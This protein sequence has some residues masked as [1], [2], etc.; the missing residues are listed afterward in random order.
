MSAA[1][2]ASELFYARIGDSDV[3]TTLFDPA[4]SNAADSIT[5]NRNWMPVTMPYLGV[6]FIGV[7]RNLDY[8]KAGLTMSACQCRS[9]FVHALPIGNKLYDCIFF[10]QKSNREG[11]GTQ[12]SLVL[13]SLHR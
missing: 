2:N 9:A 12:D 13:L 8:Y 5:I 3:F 4:H 6:S 10:H 7:A 11:T 1:G